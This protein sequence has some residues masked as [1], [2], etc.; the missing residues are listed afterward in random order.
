[1]D[2]GRKGC[3]RSEKENR[4]KRGAVGERRRLLE[5]RGATAGD[6]E[7]RMKCFRFWSFKLKGK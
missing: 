7:R 3:H 4:V 1:M 5:R 6:G 2:R